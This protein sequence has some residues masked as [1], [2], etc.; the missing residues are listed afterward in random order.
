MRVVVRDAR[1]D[2]RP[3]VAPPRGRRGEGDETTLFSAAPVSGRP[4]H[5]PHVR[6]PLRGAPLGPTRDTQKHE[7]PFGE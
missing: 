5:L 3:K 4:G 7:V 2:R 1:S 6:V